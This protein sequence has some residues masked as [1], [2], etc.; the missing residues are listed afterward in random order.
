MLDYF[1]VKSVFTLSIQWLE[2]RNL[3]LVVD[4]KQRRNK[5]RKGKRS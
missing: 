4:I 5:K 3:V 2:N 1:T